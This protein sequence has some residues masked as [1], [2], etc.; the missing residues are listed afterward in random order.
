MTITDNI[1]N[2]NEISTHSNSNIENNEL[3]LI[4]TENGLQMGGLHTIIGFSTSSSSNFEWYVNDTKNSAI[5]VQ[6]N[7]NRIS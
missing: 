2:I 5:I 7:S 6:G 4:T 3:L 1:V